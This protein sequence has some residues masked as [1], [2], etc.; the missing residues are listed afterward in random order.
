MSCVPTMSLALSTGVM[1]RNPIRL[2]HRNSAEGRVD[3][4][5]RCHMVIII[6]LG[7]VC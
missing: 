3:T 2:L 4:C 1:G 7:T 5:A 6:A